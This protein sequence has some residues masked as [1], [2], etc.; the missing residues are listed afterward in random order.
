MSHVEGLIHEQ[1]TKDIDED[2]LFLTAIGGKKIASL[3][4]QAFE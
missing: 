2:I 4:K 1:P 3:I